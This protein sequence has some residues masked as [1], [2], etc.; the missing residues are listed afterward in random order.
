MG[1]YIDGAD[2][3]ERYRELGK[4]LG[5]EEISS[6]YINYAEQDVDANLGSVFTSPFSNNNLTAK[7]LAIDFA[8]V[9]MSR[10]ARPK[11]A[12]VVYNALMKTIDKLLSG[13]L[14]MVTTSG[15]LLRPSLGAL[16]STTKLYNPL[17]TMSAPEIMHVDSGQQLAEH[18]T[19]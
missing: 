15:D 11:D 4:E 18:D 9:R 12:E 3:V 10:R 19:Y 13:K 1:R 6:T 16:D 8:Y 17:F 2:L 7:D 5:F 14:S